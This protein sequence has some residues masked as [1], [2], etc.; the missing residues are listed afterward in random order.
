MPEGVKSVGSYAFSRTLYLS[1]TDFLED[2]EEIPDNIQ[3]CF[4]EAMWWQLLLPEK[5][6]CGTPTVCKSVASAGSDKVKDVDVI[7]RKKSEISEYIKVDVSRFFVTS[8]LWMTRNLDFVR[9][10]R[11]HCF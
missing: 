9:Y 1:H 11:L 7:F 8:F 5:H 2:I 6:V 3:N 10:S 4:T